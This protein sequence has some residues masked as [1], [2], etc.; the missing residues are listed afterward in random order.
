MAEL[1][2][3]RWAAEPL[4]SRRRRKK[5]RER[6]SRRRDAEMHGV[7]ATI[8]DAEVG[9]TGGEVVSW[10]WCSEKLAR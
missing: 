5:G 6:K 8:V 4:A 10:S 1:A 2:D 7:G 9:V 3:M